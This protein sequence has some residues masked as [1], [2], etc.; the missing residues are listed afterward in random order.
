MNQ[1]K[2]TQDLI[3]GFN[4]PYQTAVAVDASH[5]GDDNDYSCFLSDVVYTL[6]AAGNVEMA[7]KLYKTDPLGSPEATKE[8]WL[9]YMEYCKKSKAEIADSHSAYKAAYE[10]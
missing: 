4:K 5:I 6:W 7:Y 1:N 3:N 2:V 9:E 10:G 8:S